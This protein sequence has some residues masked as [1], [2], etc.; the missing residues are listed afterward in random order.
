MYLSL[1]ILVHFCFAFYLSHIYFE[2]YSVPV[3][4][5]SVCY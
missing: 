1:G 3:L 4:M 2:A 5:F